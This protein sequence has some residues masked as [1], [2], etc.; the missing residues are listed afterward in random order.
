MT[1][2]Q[3]CQQLLEQ[4]GS[5]FSLS[6]VFLDPPQRQAI[7]ALYAFCRQVDDIA[8]NCR[9]LTVAQTSL[10]WWADEIERI[11]LGQATHPIGLALQDALQNFPL[12]KAW[13]HDIL[14][15]VRQDLVK[16][17]FTDRAEL[18]QYCYYVAGAVGLLSTQIFGYQDPQT[19]EYAKALGQ[20][21]QMTN[22][23]RDVLED[24][25]RNRIYLPLEDLQRFGVSETMLLQGKDCAETRALLDY[26][27]QVAKSLYDKAYALLPASEYKPQ[28]AA[29]IMAAIYARLLAKIKQQPQR[30]LRER[31][32]ISALQ[33]LWIA[34]RS[35]RAASRGKL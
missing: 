24:G 32:R 30:V 35:A 11:Y 28:R 18:E 6:F 25:Q 27:I 13:L 20:A 4:S 16:T 3:Y 17:R 10:N 9:E 8:D 15:G 7:T 22:I 1:P 5:S 21:L 19:L 12:E 2:D 33:K 23:I 14:T 26:Q 34:W 29:L 31:V